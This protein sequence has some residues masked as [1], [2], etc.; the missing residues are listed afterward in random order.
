MAGMQGDAVRVTARQPFAP[1]SLLHGIFACACAAAVWLAPLPATVGAAGA[2][3]SE[4]P[5]RGGAPYVP[6]P[7]PV[8]KAML[9]LAQVGEKD[10]VI[11]LGSGDGRVVIEAARTRGA[12]GLGVE[13]D[14]DLVE[15]SNGEARRLGVA[16]RAV[17]ERQDLFET[18]LSMATVVTLYLLPRLLVELQPRLMRLRPGTR[19]VSHDFRLGEWKPDATGKVDVP[20]RSFGPPFSTLYL[21]IVPAF[22]NGTWEGRFDHRGRPEA[23][24]LDLRQNHQEVSGSV[25]IGGRSARLDQATLSGD[26]LA[27]SAII[28][29]PGGRMRHGFEGRSIAGELVGMWTM[30]ALRP[31]ARG[32]VAGTAAPATAPVTARRIEPAGEPPRRR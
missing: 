22:V 18:D 20:E 28:D 7:W 3:A 32:G 8:V 2:Q 10:F 27:F 5:L 25:R 11:D 12:R 4:T 30:A 31:A 23:W 9:E 15:V 24:Q 14:P 26:R 1:G 6:T 21:W 17:F 19:I 16:A 13:I 29:G